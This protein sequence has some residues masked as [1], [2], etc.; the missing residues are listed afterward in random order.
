M[1]TPILLG[2]LAR[3]AAP[4]LAAPLVLLAFGLHFWPQTSSELGVYLSFAQTL[5]HDGHLALQPDAVQ[6]YGFASPLW[7]LILA[8]AERLGLPMEFTAK[9]LGLGLGLGALLLL[10]GL[11]MRLVG[12]R[13][14]R[15]L[16]LWPALLLAVSEPVARHLGNGLETGL[17]LFLLVLSLRMFVAEECRFARGGRPRDLASVL[18]LL[19]LMAARAEMPLVVLALVVWRLLA[20]MTA[21]RCPFST[22]IWVGLLI[23]LY[24][25]SLLL[26]YSAFADPFPGV[27]T[28]R[29]AFAETRVGSHTA[30]RLGAQELLDLWLFWAGGAVFA[31]VM[32]LGAFRSV[33][34]WGRGALLG[35]AVFNIVSMLVLTGAEAG[36]LGMPLLVS[37]AVLAGEGLASLQRRLW[38]LSSRVGRLG[39]AL[40]TVALA[41]GLSGPALMGTV[42]QL[43]APITSPWQIEGELLE[44]LTQIVQD[45]GHSPSQISL[46]TSEPGPAA[47]AGFRV[48]D[49]TGVTDPA[50]RRY[51]GNRMPLE[52]E[53][54]IFRDRQPD[55]ILQR[56]PYLAVHPFQQY[57]EAQRLYIQRG[58]QFLPEVRASFARRLLTEYAPWPDRPMRLLLGDRIEL[59]GVRVEPDR[60][61]LHWTISQR[62]LRP[63]EVTLRVG[64]R[65][66]RRVFIGPE[67]YTVNRWR[68]GEL[69]KQVLPVPRSLAAASMPIEIQFNGRWIP[70][71]TLDTRP[72]SL[73]PETWL[74]H[75]RRTHLQKEQWE[76]L[77]VMAHLVSLPGGPSDGAADQAIRRV[78]ELMTRGLDQAAVEQ[79]RLLR[80]SLADGRVMVG[81]GRRLSQR[82]YALA[83]QHVQSSQWPSAFALLRA[84]ALADPGSPWVARRLEEARRRLPGGSAFL[85]ELELE[86]AQ[87]A[88]VLVPTSGRLERVMTAHL[89]LD[90]PWQALAA[91]TTWKDRVGVTRRIRFL[92]AKAMA[93]VG[94]LDPSLR[95]VE[96]IIAE[97][98]PEPLER[99]CPKGLWNEL[100]LLH[101]DIMYKQ[102]KQPSTPSP[103][104]RFKGQSYP[105]GRHSLLFS[106]CISLKPDGG[107]QVDLDIWQMKPEE[108]SLELT[109]GSRLERLV[110]PKSSRA[111]SRLRKLYTLPPARYSLRLRSSVES[112]ISLGTVEVKRDANFGF[113]IPNYVG[114]INR[115]TAFG[116]T[117]VVGRSFRHR[118]LFGYVGERYADSFVSGSDEPRGMLI[119]QPFP[120]ERSYLMLLLAGGDS[121]QLGVDLVVNGQV[122]ATA[123]GHRSEVMRPVFLPI[124]S[125]R[126][127]WGHLVIRD[128][129]RD[130]WG[131]LAVDAIRTIDGPI[132]GI[133]P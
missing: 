99:N 38:P 18:P 33:N 65:W 86:L 27:I 32:L 95:Q 59:L 130:G 16:D 125:Y 61:V 131:H 19:L 29:E 22:G 93:T 7:L 72:L 132:P 42:S 70:V 88:L 124:V 55:I 15:L 40:G 109:C 31:G 89:G 90:Q 94:Y 85:E 1:K 52:L 11:S 118:R 84:A 129:A 67:L 74:R 3:G 21:G 57:P 112:P 2:R 103:E 121:P 68:P 14:L 41:L 8:G 45:L 115:G 119:S 111:V 82:L 108:V 107:V 51:S 62:V 20:R 100:V 122:R 76:V 110:L 9:A 63:H 133:A 75:R 105:V 113:E 96:A 91:A 12:R 73:D 25:G 5:V 98:S 50:I 37:S 54:L 106:H 26:C 78:D 77:D 30:L 64:Q 49:E 28:A 39:P 97:L 117:P 128:H 4:L 87:R 53:Q 102:G 120:L 48:L 47:M 24:L 58:F 66:T 6:T 104:V 92:E 81:K 17:V 127:K 126:G 83:E 35:L 69:V 123:R 36:R 13:D 101:A 71:G 79:L 23:L 80:R 34:Y 44:E 114:W 46:L 10:P 60:L 116:T 43:E 56:P